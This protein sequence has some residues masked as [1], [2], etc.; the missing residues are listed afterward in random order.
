MRIERYM[1]TVRRVT[2]ENGQIVVVTK[3]GKVQRQPMTN[4]VR[5]AIEQ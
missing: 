5:M 3:D 2:V 4:V 1:S